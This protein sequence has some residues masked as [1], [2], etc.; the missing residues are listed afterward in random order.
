VS[1]RASIGLS[2]LCVAALTLGGCA[3][4]P[5]D[6]DPVQ[7]KLKDLDTRLARIERVMANQSLL[8]V[9]NQ[10]EALRADVRGMHNDV[11]QLNNSIEA[12]RKQQRDLYADLDVRMKK[13]ESRSASPAPA[14]AASAGGTTSPASGSA[15]AG[16]ETGASAG[17]ATAENG[18]DKTAYQAAFNLLKDGQYDKA[19]AAFQKFLATYPDSSLAD[20]GQYWLGEAY[21][22]NRNFPEAQAAFQRVVDKYPQSRKLPD[23]LL[24]IGYC[25]YEMKQWESAREVLGQLVARFNDT[26]AARQAQQRLE[27]MSAEKH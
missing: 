9:A 27:K 18:E 20:N 8:D 7:I 21:Y 26:P 22:V 25:R 1:A 3:S 14:G 12:G 23:A 24:K 13:L 11:D 6:E 10:L 4:T 5:P 2:A 15:T 17:A 19:V 16:S